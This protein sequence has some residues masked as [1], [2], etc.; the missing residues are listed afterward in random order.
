MTCSR[1]LQLLE[2]LLAEEELTRADLMF[3]RFFHEALGEEQP[4]I[5]ALAAFV[6]HASCASSTCIQL[7][8]FLLS[9]AG[10][11]C[12]REQLM[13]AI[14]RSPHVSSSPETPLVQDGELL[15]LQRLFQQESE[16]AGL[17]LQRAKGTLPVDEMRLKA[18][19]ELL[20][21]DDGRE[22]SID[23]QKLSVAMAVSRRLFILGG[24]P[25]TG[26]T[27]S[28]ARFLALKHF[29]EPNASLRIGLAAP[30]GKAAQ[31]LSDALKSNY[32]E[33]E[34]RLP[35]TLPPLP[36]E[37]K[38]LHRL[39]GAR[40]FGNRYKYSS[41]Y[42]LPLDLLVVDENSMLSQALM[43]HLLLALP[44]SCQLL[45][46]G[47]PQQLPSVESGQ[48][49][50]DI[51]LPLKNTEDARLP[52]T[53]DGLQKLEKIA[54]RSLKDFARISKSPLADCA[55][56]LRVT[57]RYNENSLLARAIGAI[58]QGKAPPDES[59]ESF[60]RLPLWPARAP[61]PEALTAPFQKFLAMQPD[62]ILEWLRAFD[63]F[64][65]LT[66]FREGKYGSEELNH[67]IEKQLGI[68]KTNEQSSWY[69]GRPVMVLRND[70]SLR[71][72]NGDIG[73][74]IKDGSGFKVCFQGEENKLI[75]VRPGQLPRHET[76]FAMTVHKS[77]G[78]EFET[79]ALLVPEG[80]SKS[81]Q[82]L[83]N[84]QLVYTGMSRAMQHL[85]LYASQGGMEQALRQ[86]QPRTTGLAGRLQPESHD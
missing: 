31:R 9:P 27:T 32:A 85:L 35:D 58:N 62:S 18:G 51:L 45:L 50:G 26:K 29:L 36:G 2:K 53:H 80:Q 12:Q 61:L 84:P 65:L 40:P 33:L 41:D 39:L 34:K 17:L 38:T 37:A 19:L 10:E 48:I 14:S 71:L 76:C 64:R 22:N 25:G 47:D 11:G 16:L 52:M 86:N 73:L 74:A 4:E 54:G 72:F 78:S 13:Q 57:R 67:A 3:A 43:R 66:P 60:S 42:P 56:I 70:Y 81:Q 83:V 20:F 49:L 75:E 55:S 79:V 6:S 1:Q 68:K 46:L 21:P 69:H 23:W 82:S 5:L 8:D 15:Y 77:Q 44:D 63:R 7:D 28:V 24:G 30:T 59:D